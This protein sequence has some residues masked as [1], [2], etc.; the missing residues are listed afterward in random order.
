MTAE[1]VLPKLHSPNTGNI[2]HREALARIVKCDPRASSLSGLPNL[3]NPEPGAMDAPI[4]QLNASYDALVLSFANII[5]RHPPSQPID[6]DDPASTRLRNL[7]E[8]V[9][10][11][12]GKVFSFGMGIQ[13]K[14]KSDLG[15]LHPALR[16]LLEAVNAHAEIMGVRGPETAAWLHEVGLTKAVTLGCPSLF[17]NPAATLS[18]KPAVVNGRTRYTTAGR[19]TRLGMKRDR[20]QPLLRM[21]QRCDLDYVYQNDVLFKREYLTDDVP[22]NY[23]TGELDYDKLSERE[24]DITGQAPVFKRHFLFNN[25]DI[26]RGYATGRD[27]YIGDRFHGGVVFLQA[28]RPAGFVCCDARV[29]EL[30]T[31]L[32]LEAFTLKQVMKSTPK[33]MLGQVNDG[34]PKFR[35]SYQAALETF[36]ATCEGAGLPLVYDGESLSL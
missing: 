35:R 18:I 28:G 33:R 36:M 12:R 19:L 22:Y 6:M 34:L 30:T 11:F 20:L 1:A 16:D 31:Y 9:R 23:L 8:V 2:I 7:A 10:R 27:A 25:A 14:I 26:W 15:L 21:A 17:V 13:V 32:G 4:E 3:R 5:E 24:R 29:R